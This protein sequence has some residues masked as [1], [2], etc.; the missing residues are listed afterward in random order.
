MIK[1][2]AFDLDG[3]IGNTI[4]MCMEAIKT[5]VAPYTH[6]GLTEKEIVQTFGL[7]EKGM[8]RQIVNGDNWEEALDNFYR[9]YKDKHAM[10]P[11]PFEGIPELIKE[12]KEKSI[13]TAL[14]T[15][16]GEKSCAITLEQFR[17]QACFDSIKTG[18]SQKNSK[19]ENLRSLLAQYNLHPQEMI[20]VGDALSDIRD[21]QEV[22]ILCLSAAWASSD[23]D[24]QRL[25]ECNE[26]HV[27]YSVESLSAFLTE[28]MDDV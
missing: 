24:I 17:M 20:Y 2:V 16:K 28:R 9:F 13:L 6:H 27:F 14:V 19:S 12:L 4:P 15:G 10:C 18:N 7:N 5:A 26:G 22:G 25:E 23:T 3:T 1:L 21:C 8:I 11:H